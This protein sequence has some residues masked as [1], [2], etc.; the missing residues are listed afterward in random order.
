MLSVMGTTIA[1]RSMA[2]SPFYREILSCKTFTGTWGLLRS[3]LAFK[4]V[5]SS[6]LGA[7]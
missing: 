1:L 6:T 2:D 5:G 7:Q 3:A 4:L